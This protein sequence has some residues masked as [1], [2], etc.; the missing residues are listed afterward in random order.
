M[1]LFPVAEALSI[2]LP[3]YG[4]ALILPRDAFTDAPVDDTH[5]TQ[6]GKRKRKRQAMSLNLRDARDRGEPLELSFQEL[7]DAQEWSTQ[8]NIHTNQRVSSRPTGVDQ[9][10]KPRPINQWK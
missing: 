4:A 2:L 10:I 5:K 6:K 9:Q 1:H 7:R 8:N 3:C